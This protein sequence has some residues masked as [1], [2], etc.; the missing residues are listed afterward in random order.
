[1]WQYDRDSTLAGDTNRTFALSTLQSG[2]YAATQCVGA[3]VMAPLVRRVHF[4]H[5]LASGAAIMSVMAIAVIVLDA[6]TGGR[7]PSGG[8]DGNSGEPL[9]HPSAGALCVDA[10]HCRADP[11][12]SAC[13]PSPASALASSSSA[14]VRSA[15]TSS[16]QIP[17]LCAASTR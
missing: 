3:I 5:L 16:D 10:S 6:A 4:R 7:A 17:S 9:G 1:M 13:T 15:A 11:A 8:E 2:L 12:A 14:P